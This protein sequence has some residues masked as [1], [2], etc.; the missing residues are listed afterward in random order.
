[1]TETEESSSFFGNLT[2]WKTLFILNAL[3]G[4]IIFE[5]AWLKVLRFRKPNTDLDELYPAY[6]RDDVRNWWKLKL[7]PGAL[8]IMIP[9]AILTII[10]SISLYIFLTILLLGADLETPL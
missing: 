2:F 6:R 7:Y 8:T 4:L 9:R 3:F 10:I 1:M 5:W